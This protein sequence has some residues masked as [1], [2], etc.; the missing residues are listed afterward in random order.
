MLTFFVVS[1][2][3][4]YCSAEAIRFVLPLCVWLTHLMLLV[5]DLLFNDL[6]IR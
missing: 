6:S 1:T 2:N 5:K 4:K 3:I